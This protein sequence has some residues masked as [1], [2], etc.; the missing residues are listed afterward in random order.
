MRLWTFSALGGIAL[1]L[2]MLAFFPRGSAE[3]TSCDTPG[4]VHE[5]LCLSLSVD[6][7]GKFEVGRPLTVTVTAHNISDQ[8][9]GPNRLLLFPYGSR[10]DFDRSVDHRNI[11]PRRPFRDGGE[12][13]YP[14]QIPSLAANEAATVVLEG[15]II[16]AGRALFGI[17]T[18][19]P[20]SNGNLA[21]LL[22]EFG[23]ITGRPVRTGDPTEQFLAVRQSCVK[24]HGEV[25]RAAL[26]KCMAKRL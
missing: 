2:A 11:L 7:D 18:A 17:Q 8:A 9:I 3:V 10:V 14:L 25:D 24:R 12:E 1:I 23:T 21:Y 5:S 19:T 16:G 22:H 26:R 6:Q 15:T 4:N 20:D 13:I